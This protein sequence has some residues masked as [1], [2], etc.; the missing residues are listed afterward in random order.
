MYNPQINDIGYVKAAKWS[1]AFFVILFVITMVYLKWYE[2]EQLCAKN[3][4]TIAEAARP[5]NPSA[6]PRCP[7]GGVYVQP[8]AGAWPVCSKHG[9][10]EHLC[11]SS[12]KKK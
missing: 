2:R 5:F 1:L 11:H 6:M 3:Q 9:S 4:K 8:H 7:S 10:L 12:V